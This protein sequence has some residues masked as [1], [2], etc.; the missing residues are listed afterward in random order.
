M[1]LTDGLGELEEFVL[2]DRWTN[3]H[4]SAKISAVEG[5]EQRGQSFSS[6]RG[7]EPILYRVLCATDEMARGR[8][9]DPIGPSARDTPRGVSLAEQVAR[10]NWIERRRNYCTEL[11]SRRG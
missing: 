10:T 7:L 11:E 8:N 2:E 6:F 1:V 9:A 4:T 3:F 5:R